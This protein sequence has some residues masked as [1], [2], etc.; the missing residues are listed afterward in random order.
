MNGRLEGGARSPFASPLLIGSILVA[1]GLLW[2]RFNA[3]PGALP[4]GDALRMALQGDL[5]AYYLPMAQQVAARI[6]DG[7]RSV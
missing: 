2:L 5:L 1:L 7:V 6:A 4:E 3:R